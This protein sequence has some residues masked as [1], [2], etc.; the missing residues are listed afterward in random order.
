VNSKPN[1]NK[2]R[3]SSWRAWFARSKPKEPS[4]KPR[5]EWHHDE[6]PRW[7]KMQDGTA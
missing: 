3:N 1:L 6:C 7:L 4:T 2:Q 5:T